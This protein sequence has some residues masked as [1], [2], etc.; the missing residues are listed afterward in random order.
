MIAG[1]IA[2]ARSAHALLLIDTCQIDRPVPGALDATTGAYSPTYLP[3]YDGPCRV[4]GPGAGSGSVGSAQ[5]ADA[6][7]QRTRHALVLPHGS[8]AGVASGDRV[9]MTTGALLGT[10]YA[11]VG[12]SDS[13]SMSARSVTIEWVDD[14]A[15]PEYD[16]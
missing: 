4:K 3:I 5:A 9:Q 7:Q 16:A 11:V 6:E 12:V 1:L 13:T 14:P 2:G 15:D 10:T 8:A